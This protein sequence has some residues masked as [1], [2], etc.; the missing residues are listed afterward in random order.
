MC[1]SGEIWSATALELDKTITFAQAG[2]KAAAM[3]VV[4]SGE[5]KRLDGRNTARDRDMFTKRDVCFNDVATRRNDEQQRPDYMR[6]MSIFAAIGL[7]SVV[8]ERRWSLS[9]PS[10]GGSRWKRASVNDCWIR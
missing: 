1:R 2:D 5:G 9:T 8:F 6:R 3:E 4:V 7:V 10:L